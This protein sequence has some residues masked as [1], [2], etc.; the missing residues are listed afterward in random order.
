M[1]SSEFTYHLPP[2]AIA[3]EAIEPRDAARLLVARTLEDRVFSD[4][5]ELLDAGDLV[6]VN[7][8]RV[9][10]AR[11]HATKE[12]GGRVELLLTKQIT[13]TTWEAL[14]RPARR[15]RPGSELTVGPLTIVVVTE[16]DRGVVTLEVSPGTS[17]DEVLRE[18]GEVPLPPYFHGTLD[19]DERYQTMFARTVGS[20]AAPTAALHFT[21]GIVEALHSRG[22]RI[23]DVELEVGLDTFRPM[24]DGPIGDHEMHEERYT[25]PAATVGA[26][27]ETKA[28]GSRVV[29]AGTT[30]V[31]TLE[32]AAEPDGGVLPGSGS[33]ELFITPGFRT[34][35]VDAM[36]TNFHAPGT[37][38]IVMIAALMGPAWRAAYA[39]ALG[40]GYRFLSFGDAMFIEVDQ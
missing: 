14:V 15:I 17:V 3:Q 35:V 2:E 23:V 28:R 33:T 13:D 27:A 11:V 19:D 36:V 29:A 34:K 24:D 40:S 18:L 4:L 30:V 10:P 6:V 9:R 16:P 22:I 25:V 38:L 8:T 1:H 7:N 39:H 21:P 5:P 37:T 26:I 12:T 31:R 32:T 20:A